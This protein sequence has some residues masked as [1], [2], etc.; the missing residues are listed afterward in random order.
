MQISIKTN[1]GDIVKKIDDLGKQG[2]FA[3]AVA[4]TGTAQDIKAEE[5]KVMSQVFDRPTR[6]TLNSLYIKTAT[7]ESLEARVWVKDT[8]K[9]AHYLLP[10]IEGGTRY[11]KR[12]EALLRIRGILAADERTVPGAGAK[13]D[14]YGN[15]S[16]GQIVQ[17]ISQLGAFNLAGASQNATSSRRSRAKRA[18]V[19]YFVARKG[20]EKSGRVQHLASGIYLRKGLATVLPVLLFVKHVRYK[21]RFRFFD[22][23][24]RIVQE[25]FPERF[26][27]AYAMAQKTARWGE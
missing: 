2:R 5:V 13:L 19:G 7:K 6:Y 26:E 15:M 23:A 11:Q 9:P 3:A 24:Q 4:L 27:Q 8:D 21:E 16:R 25:R 1:F 18:V 12:Y 20:E 10:E 22:V 14:A 17:I